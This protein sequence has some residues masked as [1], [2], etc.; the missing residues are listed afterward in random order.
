MVT[1]EKAGIRKHQNLLLRILSAFDFDKTES[2]RILNELSLHAKTY[3]EHSETVPF[4][5]WISK[6]LVRKC[7]SRISQDLFSGLLNAHSTASVFESYSNSN[8]WK[9][10]PLSFWVVHLLHDHVGFTETE[11][12]EILNTSPVIVKERLNKALRFLAAA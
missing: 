1:P 10:M 4:K 5:L 8:R 6:V 7:V 9:Y 2:G 12:A 3:N 11:I